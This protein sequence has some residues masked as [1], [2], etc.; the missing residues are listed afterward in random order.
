MNFLFLWRN[1]SVLS[2][3][4]IILDGWISI[5]TSLVES[6]TAS[7]IIVLIREPAGRRKKLVVVV[8]ANSG[9]ASN[10]KLVAT[11]FSYHLMSFLALDNVLFDVRCP[12]TVA[13]CVAPIQTKREKAKPTVSRIHTNAQV[14]RFICRYPRAYGI[15]YQIGSSITGF[16][17]NSQTHVRA[18]T[19][20]GQSVNAHTYT[21]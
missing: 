15:R 10:K 7:A 13:T 4:A 5:G 20:V 6:L 18:N 14:L 2:P 8:V 1:G 21:D 19:A 3:P 12:C 9:S 16:S 11:V 17:V